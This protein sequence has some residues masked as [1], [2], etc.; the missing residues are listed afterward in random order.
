MPFVKRAMCFLLI[1]FAGKMSSAQSFEGKV[2]NSKN[3]QQGIP[4]ATVHFV[5]LGTT[6][7][8][9]SAGSW[10]VSAVPKGFNHIIVKAVGFRTVHADVDLQEGAV[11]TVSM[12]PLHHQLDKVI[13]SNNGYLHRESITSVESHKV[14]DLNSVHHSTIGQSI[15]TIPGVYQ[16]SIGVG[17][18]KP[19]IRGLSG[20]SVVTYVGGLRIEN[21]QWGDDHGLPITS[22]GISN[23]EVIKGP[24]SLLYGADALG[25][26]LYFVDAPYAEKKSL[27]GFAS[28]TYEHNSRG[29][30]NQAGIRYSGEK[31]RVQAYGGY[32]NFADYQVAGGQQA[33][34]SR[35]RQSSS[36]L[37][38]GCARKNWTIDLKYNFYGARIGL[39]GHTHDS[40]PDPSSFLTDNQNRGE[41]VPAMVVTNHFVSLDNKFFFN[42][43]EVYFTLG[44]T[45]N[46]LDE[47]EEKFFFPDIIMRLNNTLYNVK[48]RSKISRQLETIV[49]SQGMLQV[50]SNGEE[51][52][53]R[54]IPDGQTTDVGAYALLKYRK[55]KYRF[56]TGARFDYR[57]ITTDDGE[58]S[59]SFNG[60]NY[61]AGVARLGEISTARIAVSS[62]FRAPN[63]SELLSDGIHH[64]TFRYEIGNAQ[65]KSENAL[66]VDASYAI[67]LDD[68]EFIVNPFYNRIANYIYIQQTD[69][70]VGSYD[71]YG[72]EQARY[73]HLFGADVGVHFHPHRAHWMHIESSLSNV[74]AEDEFQKPV[75]LIPQS[76][77]N[78]ELRIKLNSSS[79]FKIQ[80]IVLQHRYFFKQNRLGMLE[81]ATPSF[82]LLNAAVNMV[83][84]LKTPIF[85]S[86]GVRN[87]LDN[88][89]IDHLSRLKS[90]GIPNPG[91][92]V[93]VSVKYQFSNL[94]NKLNR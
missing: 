22:L 3:E 29:V 14:S 17:I 20:S 82:H 37:L 86:L 77:W 2:I 21:Q 91:I 57:Q 83:Y 68:L 80:H 90:L 26:V 30:V 78:T 60:I 43:Q 25:G 63:T 79:T 94:L 52:V 92:N 6:V 69:S 62:G 23:V 16:T 49:G 66:Q 1:L 45:Y 34:N 7:Q 46:G 75:P 12:E 32:D 74:F 24:A 27:S 61:S 70:T 42:N 73:A 56:L 36:K 65:L 81:T 47:H 35:F 18:S 11:A 4:Y 53:E 19:V 8:A 58:Y 39:P 31:F 44:H 5:S 40:V 33:L 9:D 48:W 89:F 85:V 67:H 50:N 55:G 93:Y 38:M 88:R 15:A 84:Q 64:G 59:N 54:L 76:R 71:V 87:I 28:S 51:A 13:V 10:V 41:N 72:Y